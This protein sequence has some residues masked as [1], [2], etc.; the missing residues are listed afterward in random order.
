MYPTHF[1][2]FKLKY[3]LWGRIGVYIYLLKLKET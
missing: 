1:K 2:R 3:K